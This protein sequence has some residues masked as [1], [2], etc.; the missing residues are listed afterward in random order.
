M[1]KGKIGVAICLIASMMFSTS[2]FAQEASPSEALSED[3]VAFLEDHQVDDALISQMMIESYS[4]SDEQKIANSYN[5]SITALKN[6]SEAYGFTDEQIQAYVQGLIDTPTQ[7]ITPEDEGISTL[8]VDRPGDNGIGYEV[9]SLTGFYQAT[10]F[11]KLP[12]VYQTQR[13]SAFMM[14]SVADSSDAN[15]IDMGLTYEDGSAGTGWYRF[16]MLN[17]KQ[18]VQP[19]KINVTSQ[20]DGKDVYFNMTMGTD[21]Y[22]RCRVLDGHNF[23]NVFYDQSYYVS[24]MG[25]YRSNVTFNQQMTLCDSQKG[26]ND[27]S[28]ARNGGFKESY[29][30]NDKV[31][32]WMLSSNTNSNR[33]GVFG[34]NSTNRKQV[35]VNSSTP[36]YE[37]NVSI[38]F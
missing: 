4:L 15:V 20:A 21:G 24:S 8:A 37:E 13:T 10:A 1:K 35:T 28:Y 25:I 33:R 2:A 31:T 12:S 6:A 3:L 17:G 26:Y 7:I 5:D 23:S 9:R 16:Y 18:I 34:T 14:Y 22:A 29:L 30:Y 19:G 32:S 27:G 38:N 36:W 11:A